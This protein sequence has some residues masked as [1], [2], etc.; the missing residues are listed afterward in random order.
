[1]GRGSWHCIGGSAQVHLQE[2]EMQK[3]KIV[4]EEALQ[5][6]ENRRE[7]K[8]KQEKERYTQLWMQSFKEY[9]GKIR[10]PS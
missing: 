9:Q 8:G 4:S 10:K 5:I 6:A 3:G 2:K 1:M 7:E